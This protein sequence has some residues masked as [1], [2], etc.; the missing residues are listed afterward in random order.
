VIRVVIV[1]DQAIVRSGLARIL[2]PDD[3]FEVVA[4]CSD[5]DEVAA[6]VVEHAPDLVLIDIRMRRIDGI[7]ATRLLNDGTPT[8]PPVLVLTTFDDDDALWGA[9]DAGA[10]GFVLKDASAEDLIAA[11]RAVA[12]GAAWLDPKVAPR[13]LTAFRTN[14]R[15]RLAEAAR[16]DELTDREHDVLRL[17][18]RG[19][20]NGEIAS[21]LIVSEATVKTHVGS[22]FSKLGVRDR[23]AAI[24]FAFD[25]GLVDPRS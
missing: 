17:M 7:T 12:G 19:A 1:D 5:G 15:P 10:A 8:P 14:V 13:V 21:A 6:A 22:I 23:A 24:V 20:T 4:E 18:A 9:L 11:A 2:G 25:H 16:V 3:G